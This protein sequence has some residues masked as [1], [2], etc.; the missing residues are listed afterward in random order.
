[1]LKHH[2]NTVYGEVEVQLREFF[3]SS[4]VATFTA[5]PHLNSVT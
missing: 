1:M 2:A 3:A 4:L 5:Y